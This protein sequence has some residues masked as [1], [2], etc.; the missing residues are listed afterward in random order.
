MMGRHSI[1]PTLSMPRLPVDRSGGIGGT[2]PSLYI[3]PGMR[4]PVGWRRGGDGCGMAMEGRGPPRAG[5]AL[6]GGPPTSPA[7]STAGLP[8]PRSSS[9]RVG[10]GVRTD[11]IDEEPAR[12]Q[13]VRGAPNT[14]TDAKP[15]PP[16][17]AGMKE[18]TVAR[19]CEKE[20]GQSNRRTSAPSWGKRQGQ[21]YNRIQSRKEEY[22]M[23]ML[24]KQLDNK[25]SAQFVR[26]HLNARTGGVN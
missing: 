21:M 25:V 11:P 8:G 3:G 16:T 4:R 18:G 22:G 12:V 9:V 6:P 7:Q 14:K 17:A 13:W 23:I 2:E 10:M 5:K 24:L 20:R 15:M 1:Q 19:R 26:E